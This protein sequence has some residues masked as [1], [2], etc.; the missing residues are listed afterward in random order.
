M[1]SEFPWVV[2]RKDWVKLR[3]HASQSLITFVIADRT[4][5]IEPAEEFEKWLKM[6]LG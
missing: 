6:R 1:D 2:T 3:P 4:A 5:I